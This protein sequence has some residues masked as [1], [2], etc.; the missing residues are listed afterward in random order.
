MTQCQFC[1]SN[2]VSAGLNPGQ[3]IRCANCLEIGIFGKIEKVATHQMAWRSFWLGLSSILLLF[4]TGLPAIYYGIRSLL[5]MRFVKPKPIDRAVAITGTALGG[6]FG[7]LVGIMAICLMII[8]LIGYLT[9]QETNEAAEVV[10][11]C[12]EVFEFEIPPGTQPIKATS[13]FNN[14]RSFDFADS[15][16]VSERNVRI[17]LRHAGVSIQTN[18]DLFIDSLKEKRLNEKSLGKPQSSEIFQWEMNDEIVD[19]RKIVYSRPRNRESSE[20]LDNEIADDQTTASEMMD[21]HLYFACLVRSTGYY[22]LVV[23]FE[24]EELKLSESEVRAIFA[25]TKIVS[26]P[27]SPARSDSK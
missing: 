4:F 1:N 20:P 21:T 11:K 9:Y 2:L 8:G 17:Q 24:P 22:G 10:Q 26:Q 18:K 27:I 3:Q 25:N 15:E 7:I 23:V 6:C 16:K 13:L 12:S 14:I 5:R 19:V